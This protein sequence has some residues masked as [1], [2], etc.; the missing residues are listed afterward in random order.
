MSEKLEM[1]SRCMLNNS[2][3][4]SNV[5][6]MMDDVNKPI[7]SWPDDNY[8]DY[9]HARYMIGSIDN[10]KALAAKAYK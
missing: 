2:S 6:F 5:Q 10:W 4:P 3:G 7:W 1:T 9:I 8:F